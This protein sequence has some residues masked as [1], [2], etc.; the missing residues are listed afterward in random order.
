MLKRIFAFPITRL[1]SIVVL[2]GALLTPAVLLSHP[3]SSRQTIAFTWFAALLLTAVTLVVERFAAGESAA[4]VGLGLRLAARDAA[5]GLLLGAALFSC[6][7]F[8]LAIGGFYRIVAVHVT[9]ALGVAALLFIGDALLEELLFRG[10][11][12][13]LVEEWT[14]TWIALIVSGALFGFA[15]AANPHATLVSSLAIALEAGVLLGGAFVLVRNL[16]FPIGIHFAWNFFEGPVFGTQVSGHA[17]GSSAVS[18]YVTGPPAI[19]GG[20]FG[21]E[22]GIPAMITCLVVA[23]VLLVLAVRA[24]RTRAPSWRLRIGAA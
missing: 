8:E 16:W 22:A 3:H 12:F 13:R 24:G 15:H 9:P 11:I 23:A 1:V 20:A 6:V 4:R 10:V 17:L 18:S 5:L 14:G 21:P 19:T 7:V 2:F